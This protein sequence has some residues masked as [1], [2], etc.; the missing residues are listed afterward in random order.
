MRNLYVCEYMRRS[1]RD[2]ANIF[3]APELI[4]LL[5]ASHRHNTGR[6]SC[7]AKRIVFILDVIEY[8]MKRFVVLILMRRIKQPVLILSPIHLMVRKTGMCEFQMLH[9]WP[10][11][12][13]NT[14]TWCPIK[15]HFN[16]TLLLAMAY[17]QKHAI[18]SRYQQQE[19]LPIYMYRYMPFRRLAI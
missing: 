10:S 5:L 16:Q 7:A 11:R 13:W 4:L 12:V 3:F 9:R 6:K 2:I 14:I 1:R 19:Y 8:L 17:W 18:Q 15:Q